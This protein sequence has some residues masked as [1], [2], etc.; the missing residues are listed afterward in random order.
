[1]CCNFGLLHSIILYVGAEGE[2]L[3]LKVAICPAA[4]HPAVTFAPLYSGG[5]TIYAGFWR[6][7]LGGLGLGLEARGKARA[8]ARLGLEARG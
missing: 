3:I 5:C 2:K 4:I 6:L 1:M 8:R 7:A